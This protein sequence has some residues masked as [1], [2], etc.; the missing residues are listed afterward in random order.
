MSKTVSIDSASAAEIATPNSMDEAIE[1]GFLPDDEHYRLT[2]EFQ[3][4]PP[5][6]T[7][8]A[9]SSTEEKPAVKEGDAPPASEQDETDASKAAASAAAQTQSRGKRDSRWEKRERE[10]KTLREENARLKSGQSS[11][12]TQRSEA[13]QHS[14]AATETA[15]QGK[16][17]PKPKIDD[18]DAQG[19]PKYKNFAEWED[20]KDAWL[21]ADTIREFQEQTQ[22]SQQ[23]TQQQQAEAE[24]GRSLAK[25]FESTRA[26]YADFDQVAL[27]ENVLIPKGSVTDGFLVDSEHAGEVAYYLGQHPEITKGFYGDFD[28]KTGRFT[29]KISPQQQFRRLMAIEAEVSGASARSSSSSSSVRQVTQAS[30]PP[31]QVSGKGTVAKDAVEQ[32]LEDADFET[33]AQAQN[34]KELARLNPKR[35]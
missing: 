30:R 29:N 14:Q 23:Q 33:Y 32:A 35:K 24:I 15:K 20:A 26:K 34:A 27:S 1:T 19:K 18:V 12:E 2:G 31:H 16:A 22:R 10:L 3:K 21:R 11:Q 7:D 6:K 8:D 17:A 5:V 28:P 13:A 9:A 25:K 4:E